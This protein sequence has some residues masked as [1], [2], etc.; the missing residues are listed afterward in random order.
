VGL[1][2]RRKRALPLARV[3]EEANEGANVHE[4]E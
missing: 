3:K 4:A 2:Q 1:L